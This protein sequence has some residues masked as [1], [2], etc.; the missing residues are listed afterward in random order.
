MIIFQKL[1]TPKTTVTKIWKLYFLIL[2]DIANAKASLRSLKIEQSAG[3]QSF[4]L[5][6]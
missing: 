1:K 5:V 3:N 6:V 2:L 4:F